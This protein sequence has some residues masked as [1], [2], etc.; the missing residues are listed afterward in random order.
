MDAME[1]DIDI[2]RDSLVHNSE[3]DQVESIFIRTIR[4]SP[5]VNRII[6]DEHKDTDNNPPT[7]QVMI[8]H[9]WFHTA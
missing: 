6:T 8:N 4:H 1:H 3:G 9:S 7:D 2:V 5:Q